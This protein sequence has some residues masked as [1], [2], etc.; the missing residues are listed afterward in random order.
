MPKRPPGNPK[1]WPKGALAAYHITHVANLELIVGCNELRCDAACAQM[2]PPPASIA[3]SHIKERRAAT[4]VSLG[5]EGTLADYVPFYFA[6]R[7][8]MLYVNY[9]GGVEAN[10]GGQEEIVHLVF[11][12]RELADPGSFAI[13]DGHPVMSLTEQFDSLDGLKAIDWSIMDEEFW[14]D[15]DEDGDRKR[16]RQ[17]EFLV[18]K[19]VPANAIRL[20]GAINADIESKAEE[21]LSGL[22]SPPATRIRRDWYY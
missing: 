17:A 11:D 22:P 10:S 7:S 2:T 21:A 9:L 18:H 3:Y 14:N 5:P 19:S 4:R 8:P 16:R 6:P 13:T 1:P 20:V 15:T 12:V